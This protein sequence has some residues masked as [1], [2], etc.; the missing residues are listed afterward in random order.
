ML[1]SELKCFDDFWAQLSERNDWTIVVGGIALLDQQLH[2]LLLGRIPAQE[3]PP[4]LNARSAL[5]SSQGLI[6]PTE[7]QELCRL[8]QIHQEFTRTRR[9]MSF[10]NPQIAQLCLTL[11]DHM[12]AALQRHE[13][14][15]SK[16]R[17]LDAVLFTS[18]ALRYRP[19]QMPC[20]DF[21]HQL[22]LAREACALSG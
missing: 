3:I 14:R 20:P 5:G 17:F 4:G 9:G 12:P 19:I 22:Q 1:E 15:T 16:A 13:T 2:D 10:D 8:A 7:A 18:L 11:Y 6:S 21:K